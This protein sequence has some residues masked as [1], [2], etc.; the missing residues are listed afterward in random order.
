MATLVA[1]EFA[2]AALEPGESRDAAPPARSR[3]RESGHATVSRNARIQSP[4]SLV[5]PAQDG[6]E[7]DE[8]A[9]QIYKGQYGPVDQTKPLDFSNQP[10]SV[11][12]NVRAG[13]ALQR[14]GA[15]EL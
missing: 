1:R 4:K 14:A 6:V 11:P 12:H 10:K 9:Q 8:R 7:F 15:Q 2:R 5:N 3:A 13:P